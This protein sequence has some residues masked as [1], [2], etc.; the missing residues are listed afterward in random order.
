VITVRKGDT[1][2]VGPPWSLTGSLE[3]EFPLR[4]GV[5]GSIRV[6]DVFHSRNPG[7]YYELDPASQYYTPGW[8]T[9]PAT[10]LLDVRASV[11]WT[12]VEVA[13]FINNAFDSQPTLGNGA[14]VTLRPRTIGLSGMWRS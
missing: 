5:T 9:N 13:V 4:E 1:V 12:G 10:N 3:R 14:G 8:S 2:G 11:K 6:E 7:P